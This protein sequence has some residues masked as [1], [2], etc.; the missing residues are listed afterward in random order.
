[1]TFKSI[2]QHC[3]VLHSLNSVF[4]L[5]VHS[6]FCLPNLERD[7]IMC[8]LRGDKNHW[9]TTNYIIWKFMHACLQEQK[10][11]FGLSHQD[12]A[13]FQKGRREDNK[14]PMTAT[15]SLQL[16][17]FFLSVHSRDRMSI[18]REIKA[19]TVLGCQVNKSLRHC[20]GSGS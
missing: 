16:L 17:W 2:Q 8:S 14:S 7:Y 12:L 1:M 5:K 4:Y 10:A 6:P 11:S 20:S 15:A 9:A 19:A 13:D 3:V 18:T